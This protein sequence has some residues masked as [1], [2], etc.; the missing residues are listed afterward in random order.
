MSNWYYIKAG[1]EIGPIPSAD[2]KKLAIA[3]ELSSYDFVRRAD[4]QEWTSA[5]HVQGLFA[6]VPAS[7]H[8]DGTRAAVV[9]PGQSANCP[10][11]A[12]IAPSR[13]INWLRV[14]R[15]IVFSLLITAIAGGAIAMLGYVCI[16]TLIAPSEDMVARQTP[17]PAPK[18]DSS[19]LLPGSELDAST[20]KKA[21]VTFAKAL[22]AGDLETAHLLAIGNDSDFEFVRKIDG[23][24]RAVQRL[25]T[26]YENKFGEKLPFKA[27]ICSLAD[28]I[29]A[30]DEKIEGDHAILTNSANPTASNV[31]HLRKQGTRW[32]LELSSYRDNPEAKSIPVML[33]VV[34]A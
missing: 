20:P 1:Q 14:L 6:E 23:Y 8:P 24:V 4:M 29:D 33:A 2:L 9:S 16:H 30:L 34:D 18:M 7:I 12:S 21:A 31:P 32:I 17:N 28:Q 26:A 22:A 11:S 13:R 27:Q 19:G 3:G 25:A 5:R 15:I 10:T